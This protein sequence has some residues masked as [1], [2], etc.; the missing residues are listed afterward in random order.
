VFERWPPYRSNESC[1]L[2]ELLLGGHDQPASIWL[3]TGGSWRSHDILGI[4]GVTL[5]MRGQH[6]EAARAVREGTR[7]Q[8]ASGRPPEE[9][10]L[11]MAAAAVLCGDRDALEAA[12]RVPAP[13]GDPE[14]ALWTRLL[15]GLG[16]GRIEGGSAAGGMQPR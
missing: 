15:R 16:T 14:S 13:H 12:R 4:R 10:P 7:R 9:A 2:E 8:R 3:E 6:E 5:V 11:L 1:R